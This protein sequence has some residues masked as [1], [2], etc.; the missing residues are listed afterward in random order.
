MDEA[1]HGLEDSNVVIFSD[2]KGMD[3]ISTKE[4]PGEVL[5]PCTFSIGIGDEYER[6]GVVKQPKVVS[7][8]PLPIAFKEMEPVFTDFAKFMSCEVGDQGDVQVQVQANEG[9][10]DVQDLVPVG[11]GIHVQGPIDEGG[12]AVLVLVCEE[13]DIQD[14]V[15]EEGDVNT[16][17]HGDE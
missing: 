14:L 11:S 8:K 13:D 6:G 9:S 17:V 16:R 15:A 1:R 3:E 10:G 2:V 4:F 5:G 7:F 12:G